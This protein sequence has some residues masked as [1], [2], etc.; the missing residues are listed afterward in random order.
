MAVLGR[1]VFLESMDEVRNLDIKNS[2]IVRRKGMLQN[3]DIHID[4]IIPQRKYQDTSDNADGKEKWLIEGKHE[5]YS[6]KRR[7]Y[8]EDIIIICTESDI[9]PFT[10]KIFF[11]QKEE[12]W[13]K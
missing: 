1:N 13:F 9:S 11:S 5:G 10:I 4:V 7:S 12:N 2:R 6:Q 8:K 3:Q